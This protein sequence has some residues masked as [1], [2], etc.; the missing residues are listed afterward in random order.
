[1]VEKGKGNL[2]LA[3]YFV[4]EKE[5]YDSGSESRYS[6]CSIVFT[7]PDEKGE[8]KSSDASKITNYVH[9][10]WESPLRDK[11]HTFYDD[12]AISA[13]QSDKD[14]Y[15]DEI[16]GWWRVMYR[17]PYSVELKEAEK[18]LSTLKK[19][20]K[21]MEKL[22]KNFGNAKSFGEYCARVALVIGAKS[23][24]YCTENS[25]WS[26]GDSKHRFMTIADG[27]S[28]IDGKLKEW[29]DKHAVTTPN[30]VAV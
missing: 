27:V 19:I 26:Y 12:L 25:G 8:N 6:H 5:H 9:D 10:R 21:G 18:M 2:S 30:T 1:M 23:I 15:A 11:L 4:E 28:F 16:S 14:L 20:T 13:Y 3:L 22:Y 24:I 7:E 17:S 29:K